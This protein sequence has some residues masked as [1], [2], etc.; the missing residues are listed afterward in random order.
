MALTKDELRHY[1]ETRVF[2]VTSSG[3]DNEELFETLEDAEEYIE[4]TNFNHPPTIAICMVR[5]AYQERREWNYE[6]LSDT[7]SVVSIIKEY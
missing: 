4:A 1:S 7:F 2:F 6:D 3:E 5:H